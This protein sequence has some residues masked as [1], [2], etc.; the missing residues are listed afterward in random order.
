P[1]ATRIFNLIP[2]DIGRPITDIAY[3]LKYN[4]LA[5]DIADVL[6]TLISKDTQ[7]QAVDGSWYQM[8]I[9]PYRTVD[10]IID[11]VVITFSDITALKKLEEALREHEEESFIR[12][13]L[14]RWPGAIFIYDL[15]EKRNVY[16][17]LTASAL[18]GYPKDKLE[19]AD[20]DFWK[21]LYHQDDASRLTDRARW[22]ASA[23]EGDIL[24]REY[25]MKRA[26][27]EWRWF[28][29]RTA[30]LAWTADHRPA[31]ILE[32]LEDIT[33]Q[34]HAEELQESLYGMT[35]RAEYAEEII[36]TVHEPL[37]VLDGDLRIV[38]ANPSF[39]RAFKTTPQET[40]GHLL[41]D[42]GNRQWDI[43]ELRRLLEEI[44]PVSAD[45]EDFVVEH[46]FPG[47][48]L[49]K[50][51]INARRIGEEGSKKHL[52]LLAIEDITDRKRQ[53]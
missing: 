6:E 23:R 16:V 44:L 8:R 52:I 20:D 17:S 27:G 45:V 53:S 4:D 51:L 25:R 48:G 39:Y 50:M 40:E 2:G 29:D 11:G 12:Q 34:K 19:S 26:D 18:L 7:V 9:I 21:A 35:M 43:P 42:L 37:V 49:R 14:D 13:V 28:V 30:V 38:S 36:R 1:Y 47:I 10:N 22:L 31:R 41:Y 5:Q 15:A 46:E 3:K 33:E 32:V 24:Q